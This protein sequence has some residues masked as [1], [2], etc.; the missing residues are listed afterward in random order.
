MQLVAEAIAVEFKK[1]NINLP[2][3]KVSISDESVV[4]KHKFNQIAKMG[5]LVMLI[6]LCMNSGAITFGS[7]RDAIIGTQICI[8]TMTKF[9]L[10]VH[11]WKDSKESNIKA[12]FPMNTNFKTLEN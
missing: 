7:R 10:I 6:L 11:T 2:D 8:D 4:K 3:R 9:G 12:I 5:R 1:H